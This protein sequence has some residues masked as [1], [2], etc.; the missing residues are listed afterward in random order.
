L[1]TVVFPVPHPDPL[2]ARLPAKIDSTN[3]MP[4]RPMLMPRRARRSR[5]W[6]CGSAARAGASTSA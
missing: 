6:C 3:V 1:R 2:L 5:R 4:I